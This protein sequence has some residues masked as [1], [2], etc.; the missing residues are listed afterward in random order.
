MCF[1]LYIYVN[2]N[3][4]TKLYSECMFI[5]H[6]VLLTESLVLV[7]CSRKYDQPITKTLNWKYVQKA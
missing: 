6:I 1:N 7:T 4:A 2:G 5:Q 3:L